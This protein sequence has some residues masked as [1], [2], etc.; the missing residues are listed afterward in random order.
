MAAA[1]ALERSF[2]ELS[3]AERERPRHFREF[4]VCGIG[5]ANALAGAV[6]YSE[7]AGGFYYM[8]SGKLFSVTRNRFIHWKTSGDTL[9][10]VEESL[11]V[12]LLNNTV[13]LK[14]QNCSLLPGGV[15]ISETQN[16]VII[17]ILTNQTVHRLLL[18]HPSRM[19]R[20]VSWLSV[21]SFVSQITFLAVRNLMQEQYPLEIEGK[22]ALLALTKHT[23]IVTI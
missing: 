5:T 15:H 18:P 19:Y 14:F 20:S 23:L 11:D 12:N 3:G 1:G 7:S 21:I 8:E 13:R 9:E 22:L 4:T 16:H 17:L 2:V 6:K 10:L